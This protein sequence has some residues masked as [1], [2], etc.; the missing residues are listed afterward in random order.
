MARYVDLKQTSNQT[1]KL[2][3]RFG[4]RLYGGSANQKEK[5][6]LLKKILGKHI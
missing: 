5:K 6:M 4:Q 2:R 3:H 1:W